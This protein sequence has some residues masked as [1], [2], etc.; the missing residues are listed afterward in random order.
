MTQEAAQFDEDF[1][2]V[3]IRATPSAPSDRSEASDPSEAVS[4][5]LTA[6]DLGALLCRVPYIDLAT[7]EHKGE[8]ILAASD[9]QRWIDR[10]SLI[11]TTG[12]TC[13]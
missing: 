1:G 10:H 8:I 9:W 3:P 7:G 11:I 12:R 5:P 6:A 13:P 2:A 4:T